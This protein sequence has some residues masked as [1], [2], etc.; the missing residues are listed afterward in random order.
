MNEVRQLEQECK[1]LQKLKHYLAGKEDNRVCQACT[2]HGASTVVCWSN[3]LPRDMLVDNAV[4][5]GLK[6][7]RELDT[8]VFLRRVRD[9]HNR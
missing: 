6:V 9:K 5:R 2:A 3:V 8:D 4:C 7:Q 1:D